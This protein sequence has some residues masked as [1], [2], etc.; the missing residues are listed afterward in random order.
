VPT[1]ADEVVVTQGSLDD[2]RFVTTY[3]YPGR[4]T[5]AVSFNNGKWLNHYRQLIETAAPFPPPA[6]RRTGRPT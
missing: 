4:V 5:A 2:H 6:P 3:G 1:F